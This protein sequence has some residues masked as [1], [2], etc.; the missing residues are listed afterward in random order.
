[1]AD[2]V[3]RS[4]AAA[5]KGYNQ[6]LLK[7]DV[8]ERD[9][10]SCDNCT[11]GCDD[12]TIKSSH[13]KA[14]YGASASAGGFFSVKRR[15]VLLCQATVGSSLSKRRGLRREETPWVEQGR[16]RRGLSKVKSDTGTKYSEDDEFFFVV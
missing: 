16:R 4:E 7:S 2:Q 10:L 12:S 1:M 9:I 6:S 14:A 5:H 15:W 8:C 11:T 3:T 13:G